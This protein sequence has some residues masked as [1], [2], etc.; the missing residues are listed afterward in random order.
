MSL[1]SSFPYLINHSAGMSPALRTTRRFT[2]HSFHSFMREIIFL[3]AYLGDVQSLSKPLPRLT[4]SPSE[5]IILTPRGQEMF[6]SQLIFPKKLSIK[7]PPLQWV[8]AAEI[9]FMIVTLQNRTLGC[10]NQLC[11]VTGSLVSQAAHIEDIKK[12]ASFVLMSANSKQ[13]ETMLPLLHGAV[14]RKRRNWFNLNPMTVST[15]T[16]QSKLLAVPAKLHRDQ[17]VLP[18]QKKLLEKVKKTIECEETAEEDMQSITSDTS[19]LKPDTEDFFIV[20]ENET[21]KP[22]LETYSKQIEQLEELVTAL[23]RQLTTYREEMTNLLHKK[24]CELN[25]VKQK[26]S[27]YVELISRINANKD[28][29]FNS[30]ICQPLQQQLATALEEKEEELKRLTAYLDKLLERVIAHAPHVLEIQL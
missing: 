5:G 7:K 6:S 15:L 19:T 9:T 12:S 30:H 23:T 29:E 27:K 24:D 8:K 1:F 13:D 11:P 21:D 4:D 10:S 2:I 20:N 25:E 3:T 28:L 17:Q 26:L 14:T 18:V 16:L 22:K